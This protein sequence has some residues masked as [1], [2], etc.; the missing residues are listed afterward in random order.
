MNRK[1]TSEVSCHLFVQAVELL[2]VFESG[3]MWH[4]PVAGA[5]H[6]GGHGRRRRG[7]RATRQAVNVDIQRNKL[8]SKTVEKNVDCFLTSA[9][10]C[11]FYLLDPR[12]SSDEALFIPAG[13]P[14]ASPRGEE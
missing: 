13:A 5:G 3:G 1:H 10:F 4:G 6:H 14:E 8:V 11:A 7:C 2:P 12:S 9:H